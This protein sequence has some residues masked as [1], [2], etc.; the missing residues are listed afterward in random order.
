MRT[1]LAAL[2]LRLAARATVRLL[3]PAPGDVL[4]VAVDGGLASE[5]GRAVAAAFREAGLRREGTPVVAV[6]V[7]AGSAASVEPRRKPREDLGYG[8][9][10]NRA[11]DAGAPVVAAVVDGEAGKHICGAPG[12]GRAA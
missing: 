6:V 8:E 12:P 4:V 10:R 3:S 9:T 11:V 5:R 7:P 2:A 1:A